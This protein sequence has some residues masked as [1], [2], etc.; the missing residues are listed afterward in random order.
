MVVTNQNGLEG[1]A[2]PELYC[3]VHMTA[4]GMTGGDIVLI[5]SIYT[6]YRILRIYISTHHS[7]LWVDDPP[8]ALGPISTCTLSSNSVL[9]SISSSIITTYPLGHW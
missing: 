9:S 3:E 2:G 6:Q 5:V 4:A 8:H 7:S 1:G